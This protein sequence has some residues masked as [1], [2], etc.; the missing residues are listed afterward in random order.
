MIY[1]YAMVDNEYAIRFEAFVSKRD[2]RSIVRRLYRAVRGPPDRDDLSG[3]AK[4]SITKMCT[5]YKVGCKFRQA[6]F[7]VH[8]LQACRQI[9]NEAA[10]VFYGANMFSAEGVA[11]LYAFLTHFQSRLPLL[12][13]LGMACIG[14]NPN[15]YRG[16][17][18]IASTRLC[19]IFPIL[20]LATNLEALYLHSPV[21][22]SLSGRPR[23][24]AKSLFQQ[25]HGWMHALGKAKGNALAVLDVLKMPDG[26]DQAPKWCTTEEEQAEFRDELAGML[27]V[28]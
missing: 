9:D 26:R 27:T 25:G 4:G 16:A 3:Q 28:V 19:S 12:R 15:M 23:I 6:S 14:S 10:P 7:G 13:K 18:H 24:A 1:I 11:H 21:L 17:Q 22:L 8:L 20:A 5:S 2:S